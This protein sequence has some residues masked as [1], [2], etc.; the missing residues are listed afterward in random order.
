[1]EFIFENP[2]FIVIVL[3]IISSLFNRLK[4]SGKDQKQKRP[5]RPQAPKQ[6]AP[7][8][9]PA[10]VVVHRE[11]RD[12]KEMAAERLENKYA[13][14]KKQAETKLQSL[15]EKQQASAERIFPEKEEK[16]VK[17]LDID[18]QNLLNGVILAEVLGPPRAK[19]PHHPF[20][21]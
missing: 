16:G 14:L 17:A 1:M 15:K 21:R 10:P 19:R 9:A 7:A 12:D 3:G 20:K 13:E 5:A 8:P 2:I 11:T 18:R 4:D 6:S